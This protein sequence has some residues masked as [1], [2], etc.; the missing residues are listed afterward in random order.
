M[1]EF[2]APDGESYYVMA[3]YFAAHR[4]GSG[5]GIY[6]YQ[7]EA[8]ELLTNLLHRGTITGQISTLRQ[9][10]IVL[11]PFPPGRCSTPE[12]KMIFFSPISKR[13]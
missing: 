7:A 12:H 8:D 6:N 4:S 13:P 10:P 2:V 1:S 11:P 3:L 5:L 9:G